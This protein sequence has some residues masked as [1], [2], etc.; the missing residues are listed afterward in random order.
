VHVTD[1]P[2]AWRERATT[3]H[4]IVIAVP[5][6]WPGAGTCG[7]ASPG[8]AG[9]A[10]FA[11]TGGKSRK[12]TASFRGGVSLGGRLAMD[13]ERQRFRLAQAQLAGVYASGPG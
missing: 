2:P 7:L 4:S 13:R 8:R 10:D 1:A 12:S 5:Q 3:L 6:R 9:P 11:E